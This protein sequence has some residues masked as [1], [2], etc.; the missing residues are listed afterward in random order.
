MP[1]LS[2]IEHRRMAIS[3][4]QRS[5]FERIGELRAAAARKH[6]PMPKQQQVQRILHLPRAQ[7]RFV[8]QVIDTVL[9]EL[10]RSNG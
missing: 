4:S 1:I 8:M 3:A 10:G 2:N 9:A 7:Q 6:E 5:L